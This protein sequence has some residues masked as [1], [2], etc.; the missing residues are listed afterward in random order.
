MLVSTH[1]MWN[2]TAFIEVFSAQN[3]LNVQDFFPVGSRKP[4]ESNYHI[5]SVSAI[6]PTL[7]HQTGQKGE[8]STRRDRDALLPHHTCPLLYSSAETSDVPFWRGYQ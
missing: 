2:K 7:C 8:T 1:L 3:G 4:T 6:L 5:V